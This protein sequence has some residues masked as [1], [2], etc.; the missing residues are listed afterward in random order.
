VAAGV[1]AKLEQAQA[2]L[3]WGPV[4][5]GLLGGYAAHR[6]M[7]GRA[8]VTLGVGGG[9]YVLARSAIE[10]RIADEAKAAIAGQVGSFFAEAKGWLG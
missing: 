9:C 2:W 6:W 3:T 5:A 1:A 7:G 10:A 4:A 8:L